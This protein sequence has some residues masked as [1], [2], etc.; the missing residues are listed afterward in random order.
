MFFSV[1]AIEQEWYV[2][3]YWIEKMPLLSL[4]TIL[5]ESSSRLTETVDKWIESFTDDNTNEII[6]R[7]L[8]ANKRSA[9]ITRGSLPGVSEAGRLLF[10][11]K[12]AKVVEPL[13]Y[14]VEQVSIYN[15][16]AISVVLTWKKSLVPPPATQAPSVFDMSPPPIV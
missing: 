5:D 6:R 11:Q 15:D 2:L 4:D 13:G 10:V 1:H 7:A 3:M 14:M 16:N 9:S 8:L 12:F